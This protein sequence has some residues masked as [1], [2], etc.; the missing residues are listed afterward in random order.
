MKEFRE[1]TSSRNTAHDPAQYFLGSFTTPDGIHH[2]DRIR[3]LTK[4]DGRC[5]GEL[6]RMVPG[7]TT[8]E[9][10]D[11]T[12]CHRADGYDLYLAEPGD[13]HT[14]CLS[15]AIEAGDIGTSYIGMIQPASALSAI[16][17]SPYVLE[18]APALKLDTSPTHGWGTFTIDPVAQG[19]TVLLIR[20]PFS[21]VQTPYSFRAGDHRHIEPTGYGHFINHACDP[22]CRIAYREDARPVLVA[23]R[24]LPAGAEITFDYSATE[25]TLAHTFACQCPS[26]IHKL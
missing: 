4:R 24:N 19:D 20:G 12:G 22:S 1:E 14:E 8:I 7:S 5:S 2:F 16:A 13:T 25:G 18:N 11:L 9:H 15:I 6:L 21:D 17:G 23:R 3:L 10:F 26:E